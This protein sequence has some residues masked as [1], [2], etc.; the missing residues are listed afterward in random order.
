MKHRSRLMAAAVV[1]IVACP[2][3]AFAQSAPADEGS[4]FPPGP[5]FMTN[6]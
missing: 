5:F 3:F 1:A 2:A 6:P 4:G